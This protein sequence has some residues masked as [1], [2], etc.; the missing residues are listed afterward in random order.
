MNELSERQLEIVRATIFLIA[1]QGVQNFSI[2]KLAKRVGV[3]EPAIYR[4]FESKDDLMIKL[5][6]H[7][8]HNWREMLAELPLPKIPVIEQIRII[9]GEVMS[10]F[11]ENQA[12]TKTL[13]SADLFATESGMTAILLELKNEGLARFA[14][15]IANGQAAGEIR[16]GLDPLATAK[17]VFGSIWW[18]VTDWLSRQCETD[19]FAEWSATWKCLMVLLSDA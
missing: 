14:E 1:E 8:V 16:L 17:V 7:I 15:L 10:Y 4:H 2:R 5:A 3:T 9:L 6:S 13:F 19:L 12:F 18:A 11:D